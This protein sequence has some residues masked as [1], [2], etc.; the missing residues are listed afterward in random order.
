[1]P[2]APVAG[3][4]DFE[5]PNP[6]QIANSQNSQDGGSKPVLER[7]RRRRLLRNAS[8][9]DTNFE[10]VF[11]ACG[12][13]VASSLSDLSPQVAIRH[14]SIM[15]RAKQLHQAAQHRFPNWPTRYQRVVAAA[16][17][18]YKM[19]LSD[20]FLRE[21]CLLLWI[22]AGG[23]TIRAHGGVFYF[24]HDDGAFMPYKGV[25][26]ESICAFVKDFLL[27]LEGLF[28]LLPR[29][30]PR[31]DAGIL[32]AVAESV[33]SSDSIDDYFEA[34]R[35]ASIYRRGER[36]KEKTR[37]THADDAEEQEEAGVAVEG[38]GW[39]MFTAGG[40]SRV[41]IAMQRQLLDDKIY[42]YLI[43]WCNTPS[44]RA[45]GVAYIDACILYDNNG[46][47]VQGVTKG[48]ERNVYVRIAHPLLDPVESCA[49]ERV[50]RFYQ[51]TFWCNHDV[52]LC[53]CAA[54][55]LAKRGENIVRCFIGI[56]PGGVG[57]SLYSAHL[58]AVYGSLHAFFDLNVWYQ[59]EE[60]RVNISVEGVR[61]ARY[62]Q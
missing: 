40:F 43:E 61:V 1:L 16:L 6:D 18:V 8:T 52:F 37:G 41:G 10:T 27:H 23:D 2:P 35:L 54:Q 47:H 36:K 12:L 20:M 13:A 24:Y 51:Q 34:C 26:P 44:P 3:T 33:G 25:P 30:C 5:D 53:C 57:Q 62:M 29:M 46:K 45:A 38:S 60:S 42:S 22:M 21:Y 7:C 32:D 11:R 17:E 49:R 14:S 28:R 15:E 19:R 31:T 55:A 50:E 59:E 58:A 4:N 48:P 39:T 56:S 9:S